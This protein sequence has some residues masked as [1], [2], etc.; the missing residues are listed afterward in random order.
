MR[1]PL[2]AL[3]LASLQSGVSQGRAAVY[4]GISA[5]AEPFSARSGA[6]R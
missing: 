3:N 4:S 5:K 1:M 2:G 6:C